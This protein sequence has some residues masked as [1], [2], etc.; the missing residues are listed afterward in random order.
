[1]YSAVVQWSVLYKSVRFNS[2]TVVQVLCF[3]IALLTDCSVHSGK[4]SIEVSTAVMLLLVS[5]SILSV[6]ISWI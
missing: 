5:P 6:F 4:R 3:L 2:L 1:M